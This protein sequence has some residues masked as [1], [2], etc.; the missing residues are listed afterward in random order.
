[1]KRHHISY[2][3]LEQDHQ[4]NKLDLSKFEDL[5]F[6]DSIVMQD[7][8]LVGIY[9]EKLSSFE[10][11]NN[12]YTEKNCEKFIAGDPSLFFYQ[13]GGP[14]GIDTKISVYGT[15]KVVSN[16]GNVIEQG[17]INAFNG[18]GWI[19]FPVNAKVVSANM[20]NSCSY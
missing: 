20:D 15:R 5:N 2:E 7:G 11:E 17:L 9:T 16:S 12:L 8:Q 18:P 14:G 3:E 10:D 13:G 19:N 4:P 1:M 6:G